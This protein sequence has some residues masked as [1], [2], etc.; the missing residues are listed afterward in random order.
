MIELVVKGVPYT[1]FVSA[2][3]AVSLET[4]ANDFEFSASAVTGFP[5]FKRGDS[6]VITV[7]GVKVLTG[8]IDEVNGADQNGSHVVTY[9][10]R[11]RTGD[12]IDSTIDQISDLN[13][14]D[15]LTLKRIIEIAIENTGGDILVVDNVDPE[16]FNVAEDSIRPEVGQNAVAFVSIYARKRQSLLTSNGDG[17]IE[18]TQSSPTDSGAVVQ[19]LVNS[20]SNNIISQSWVIN[21]SKEFNKYI[22]RGQLDP[23]ALNF[24]GS[25]DIAASVDQGGRVT[26]SEIRAGRQKVVVESESYSDEQL[27]DRAK[28]SKQL[29]KSRATRFNCSVKDHQK[30]RGGLWE[31]NTLVQVNSDVADISRKMLV[32]TVTF[33]QGEG[34]PTAT[35]LEFVEKDVYTIDDLILSQKPIGEQNNAFSLG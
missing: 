23:G 26:N 1:D 24:G 9:S 11:D 34:Q 19:R 25:T 5:P 13:P 4:L 10:G 31:T 32:N 17:N 2:K 8:F 3:A 18:I 28:W 6:V 14:N 16:A 33:T 7:D 30:P 35:S 20:D 27:G 12:F 15:T 21:G 22:H 29:A